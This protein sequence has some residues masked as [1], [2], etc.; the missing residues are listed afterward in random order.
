MNLEEIIVAVEEGKTVHWA[1]RN[2]IV[3]RSSMYVG[4]YSIRCLSN[5]H[6]SALVKL[7]GDLTEKEEEFF[8]SELLFASQSEVKH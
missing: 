6:T 2:Y 7:D 3:I 4:G 8:V 1:N 5:Q